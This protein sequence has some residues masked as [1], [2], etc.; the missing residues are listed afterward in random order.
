MIKQVLVL[1][2]G[3]SKGAFTAGALKYLL[4]DKTMDFKAAVGTSTGALAGG[5]A[6]LGEYEYLS[7]IYG[8]VS[9]SDIYKNGPFFK[10]LNLFLKVGPVAAS[11]KP[12]HKLVHDYYITQGKLDELKRREK[13]FVVTTV[14]VHTG[15]VEYISSKQYANGE[16]TAETFINGV[17][18]SCSEPV[19]TRPI[20]IYEHEAGSTSK[21]TL[22]YD[23]GVREFLPFDYAIKKLAADEIWAISTH[24]MKTEETEWGNSTKPDKVNLLKALGWT[25]SLLLNEVER[26]DLFRAYAFYRLD[27]VKARIKEIADTL[28]LSPED[29][30]KLIAACED[31]FPGERAP[32]KKLYVITPSKPMNTSLEFDPAIMFTYHESGYLAA[33]KFFEDLHPEFAETDWMLSATA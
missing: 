2:G 24:P 33:E 12:L 9:D 22:F 10:L 8:Y 32:L 31:M 20:Q 1:S 13:E 4:R 27:R 26:G 29:T 14:N 18:A 3:A 28:T 23:G 7:N 30:A 19:F 17:V 15:K 21:D 6:L 25:I 5:P 11:M 16:I